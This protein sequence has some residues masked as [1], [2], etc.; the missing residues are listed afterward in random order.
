MA[1]DTLIIPEYKIELLNKSKKILNKFEN[2][3]KIENNSETKEKIKKIKSEK[4]IDLKK[5]K[6][7][8]QRKRTIRPRTLWV[9]RKKRA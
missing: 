8:N 9:R 5:Q 1:D 2:I 3:E 4:I 6:K 7:L